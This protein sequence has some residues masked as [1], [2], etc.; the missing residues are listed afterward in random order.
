M[1]STNHKAITIIATSYLVFA[2]H[3]IEVRGL[4]HKF[5]DETAASVGIDFQLTPG[6][7]RAG[8]LDDAERKFL[9]LVTGK[10]TL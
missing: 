2:S 9:L 8:S 7:G 1:A 4:S 5:Q 3:L 6:S 10:T